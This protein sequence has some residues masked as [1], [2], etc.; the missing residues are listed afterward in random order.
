MMYFII[1]YI[2]VLCFD[3]FID[4]CMNSFYNMYFNVNLT[5]SCMAYF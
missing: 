2:L 3:W 1:V 5:Q 4:A